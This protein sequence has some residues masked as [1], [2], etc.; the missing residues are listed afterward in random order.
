M[1]RYNG[2]NA[3]FCFS[4]AKGFQ[5]FEIRQ[6]DVHNDR[7]LRRFRPHR[8]RGAN[9]MRLRNG[10][11]EQPAAIAGERIAIDRT[12]ECAG[13]GLPRPGTLGACARCTPCSH[14]RVRP[15]WRAAHDTERSTKEC[16]RELTGENSPLYTNQPA[17]TKTDRVL[18]KYFLLVPTCRRTI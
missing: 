7:L 2:E 12:A 8:E 1:R 4:V 13:P 14:K 18:V 9:A 5:S 15:L 6:V 11:R 3:G 10:N 17:K 16:P